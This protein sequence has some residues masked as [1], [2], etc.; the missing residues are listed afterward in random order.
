MAILLSHA[1]A[2]SAQAQSTPY[3]DGG[4]D[5]TAS[6]VSNY[7]AMPNGGFGVEYTQPVAAGS[8]VM[9]QYGLLYAIPMVESAPRVAVAQPAPTTDRPRGRLVPRPIAP[10]RSPVISSRLVLWV[11]TVQMVL[12]FTHRQRATKAMVRATA[13]AIRRG[14]LRLY[15]ERLANR[16]LIDAREPT[17]GLASGHNRTKRKRG[18]VMRV[19]LEVASACRDVCGAA[20]HWAGHTEAR[21]QGVVGGAIQARTG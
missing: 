13:R 5:P 18:K 11:G 2:T 7:G 14:R 3:D 1:L 8:L 12:S 15:V 20:W 10:R 16:L 4:F 21:A 9:D 17:S 19:L 6:G